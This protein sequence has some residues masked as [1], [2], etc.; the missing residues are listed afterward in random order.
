MFYQFIQT[1]NENIYSLYYVLKHRISEIF[2]VNTR[3]CSHKMQQ[4]CGEKLPRLVER[5]L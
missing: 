4:A 3:T 2:R 1:K 5:K